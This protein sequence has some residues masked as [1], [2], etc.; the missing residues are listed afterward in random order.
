M[1]NSKNQINILHYVT[2]KKKISAVAKSNR[3]W[4]KRKKPN[5]ALLLVWIIVNCSFS[6]FLF[7]V[8]Y[9][10][11]AKS[12]LAPAPGEGEVSPGSL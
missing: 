7:D 6:S 2:R 10:E 4:S 8:F 5:D 9:A 11:I 12:G 3:C 1:L